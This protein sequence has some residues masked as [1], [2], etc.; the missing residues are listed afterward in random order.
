L[1]WRCSALAAGSCVRYPEEA[2]ELEKLHLKV[3]GVPPA[4][5]FVPS[6]DP[7]TAP[8]IRRRSSS[9]SPADRGVARATAATDAG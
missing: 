4:A 3:G 5:K 2:R 1:K 6:S 8:A 7:M 9:P